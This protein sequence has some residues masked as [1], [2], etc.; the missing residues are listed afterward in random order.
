MAI[1]TGNNA[2]LQV[3][4]ELAYG[5]PVDAVQEY[6][7][8][9][10]SFKEEREKKTEGV[11]IGSKG[12]PANYTTKIQT[13]GEFSCLARP[14]DIGYILGAALGEE[15]AVTTVG[16]TGKKHTFTAID[17]A[18]SASL[19][20]LT[21]VIDR[22]AD[23][24]TYSGVKIDNMTLD[25]SAGEMVKLTVSCIGKDE[26]GGGEIQT[27]TKSALKPFLF[28]GGIVKFASTSIEVTSVNFE[29]ANNLQADIQTNLT[30]QYIYEPQPGERAITIKVDTLFNDESL[31]QYT[32]YYKNDTTFALELK[33]QSTETIETGLYYSLTISI[34]V[35]QITTSDFSVSGKD[36]LKHSFTLK[37]IDSVTSELITIELVNKN[38]ETYI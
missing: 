30:G 15:A 13:K 16:T 6:A 3:G 28:S 37:A 22:I 26:E 32:S 10:E 31:S 8:F 25:A 11:I 27:L 12:E 33:F 35:C 18:E 9:S 36:T 23:I 1:L 19:P 29:Y 4:V 7:F 2:K 14:D 5:T 21:V 17:M 20:S 38:G 24:F 34:P